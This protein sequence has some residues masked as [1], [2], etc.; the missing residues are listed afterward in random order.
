MP[1]DDGGYTVP[2]GS[3]VA[4]SESKDSNQ[5]ANNRK[6]YTRRHNGRDVIEL[7]GKGNDDDEELKNNKLTQRFPVRFRM[8][9]DWIAG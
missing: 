8:K 2:S 9:T 4:G 7:G 6:Q 1:T 3:T 5:R